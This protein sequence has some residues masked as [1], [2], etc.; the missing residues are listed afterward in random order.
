MRQRERAAP[1]SKAAS[2]TAYRVLAQQPASESLPGPAMQLPTEP[3]VAAPESLAAGMPTLPTGPST[4]I[5]LNGALQLAGVQNPQIQIAIQRVSQ[6]VAER[7]FA[8][9]QILPTLNAGSN[10]DNHTGNLQQSSGN[11]LSVNR[12]SLYAGSGAN[13]IAAGTV[14]IPGVVWNMNMGVAAF[15]FLQ[16]R[17]TV[18]EREFASLATRNEMTLQVAVGYLE[19]LRVEQATA[20]AVGIRDDAREIARLTANY[21]LTGQ[22][23]KA[24]ADRAATELRAR[25]TEVLELQGKVLTASARLCQL[26]NLDPS[27]RLHSAEAFAAPKQIVSAGSFL[28]RADRDRPDAAARVGRAAGGHPTVLI[29]AG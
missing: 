9:A 2:P 16:S 13:A 22:G 28:A 7:Q 8:A 4:P 15:N 29:R 1:A 18:R 10:Y 25:E 6:A 11:I 3:A 17:Q 5:D 12:S 20:I 27:V 23:R 21:V 24:D 14:N 26:L 19:L